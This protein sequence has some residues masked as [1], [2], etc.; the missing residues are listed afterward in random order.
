[1]RDGSGNGG[2][3]DCAGNRC[4]FVTRCKTVL[5]DDVTVLGQLTDGVVIL[6]GG[7]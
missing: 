5:G 7:Y 2:H 4:G 1:M 6:L 3:V